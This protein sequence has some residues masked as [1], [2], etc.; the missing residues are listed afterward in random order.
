MLSAWKYCGS[1]IHGQQPSGAVCVQPAGPV[2]IAP[3]RWLCLYSMVDGRGHDANCGIY[4]ELRKDT[5][6]GQVLKGRVIVPGGDDTGYYPLGDGEEYFR[7]AG[8]AHLFG[9]QKT[10]IFAVT[11]YQH[12]QKWVNGVL[13]NPGSYFWRKQHGSMLMSRSLRLGMLQLEYDGQN[14]DWKI[15]EEPHLL[16]QAG[17]EDSPDAFCEFG[18]GFSLNHALEP[19]VPLN[20]DG[21][22]FLEYVTI[23]AYD[24][25]Y[26]IG[27]HGTVVPIRYAFNR[28][29]RRYQ[30]VQTGRRWRDGND[31]LGEVSIARMPDG[32]GDFLISVRQ[33]LGGGDIILAKVSDP[34]GAGINRVYR[35]KGSSAPR[36]LSV[37][38]DGLMRLFMND[39]SLSPYH[40]ERNPLYEYQIFPDLSLGEGQ[41]IADAVQQALPWPEPFFDMGRYL[42]YAPGKEMLSFRAFDR[43]HVV[44]NEGKPPL[45]AEAADLYGVH[46]LKADF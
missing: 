4:G 33:F 38:S 41:V 15:V 13:Q 2:E 6:D 43:T 16:T 37:R 21:T 17:W 35:Y 26:M 10:G 25:P 30:W 45:S 36:T 32:S 29:T 19:P 5:P 8:Q 7:C 27:G 3:G 34:F 44:G 42:E 14:D 1:L 22:E 23:T 46:Y 18:P 28:E 24:D 9:S 39:S 31:T 20:D 40:H 12:A 11:Y